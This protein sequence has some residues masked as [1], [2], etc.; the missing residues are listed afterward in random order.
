MSISPDARKRRIKPR[1]NS[2]HED[3]KHRRRFRSTSTS[4][5]SDVASRRP[6]RN[7][8]RHSDR[9]VRR[10]YSSISP[11]ARGRDRDLPG[12][13]SKRQR[14]RSISRDKGQIER[15]IRSMTPASPP[16]GDNSVGGERYNRVRHED[17]TCYNDEGRDKT[18]VEANGPAAPPSRKKR[19]LS[20]YSKRLALTQ[21]M[22]M[23][24]R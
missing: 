2:D 4:Y 19:S 9:N 23:G 12:T 15:N 24:T 1:Q 17:R 16:L 22:N 10:R 21:A 18:R 11:D 20:P 8:S 13:K 3:Q 5:S 7:H 6:R 14:S